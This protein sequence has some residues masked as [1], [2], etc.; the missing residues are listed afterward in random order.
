MQISLHCH[1]DRGSGLAA[2]ELGLM[3]GGD[4][5]EGC[6]FGNGERTGNVDLVTIAL[7]MYSQGVPPN[8]DF[9]D[10]KEVIETVTECNDLPVHP[11]HP[12]AG[13]LVFT[14][15]SGSHQDAIKKG[16][17]AHR[18]RDDGRWAMPYLAIDPHD[19][20]CD[21]EA[22]IR[23]NSQSGK[24]GVAYLIQENLGFDMP[25]KMQVAFYNVVQGV[26]DR[27]GR[28]MTIDDLTK[29]FRATYHLGEGYEGRFQLLD[30]ALA[31]S[32]DSS[33]GAAKTKKFSGKMLDNGQEMSLE[34]YGNGI[35]SA[36]LDAM[37]RCS[38]TSF[39]IA[40]Y[41]EEALGEGSDVKAVS[42]VELKD[43]R[44][45]TTWGVGLDEEC[46]WLASVWNRRL[47][48]LGQ[49]DG[50]V[51]QSHP[52]RGLDGFHVPRRQGR[53]GDGQRRRL[54]DLGRAMN[55]MP[56][57]ARVASTSS[58]RAE[59][60]TSRAKKPPALVSSY[61]HRDLASLQCCRAAMSSAPP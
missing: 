10:I 58:G 49:R 7:N 44:G 2:T 20:G 46:A 4:R 55:K 25:R 9:S 12:Y 35:M 1:N 41:H 17:A 24:G 42:Y 54:I 30:Y 59:D 39:E 33:Q 38:G 40:S 31:S 28:E 48:V 8:L 50:L 60:S 52:Q 5:V 6:L 21:Y 29:S 37:Y 13:E 56:R 11:R 14:A 27:T 32:A 61:V 45:R 19:I 47:T 43:Q 23:V 57:R 36:M 18:Q 16:F 53:P 3:A 34:G 26:A 51:A 15:F 22:V